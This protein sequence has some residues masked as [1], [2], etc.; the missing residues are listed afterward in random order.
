MEGQLYRLLGGVHFP[1]S[2]AY[3]V[4]STY[5]GAKGSL[6]LRRRPSMLVR[7]ELAL[8]WFYWRR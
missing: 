8:E 4:V 3:R 1:F 7:T 5:L 2:D 6:G